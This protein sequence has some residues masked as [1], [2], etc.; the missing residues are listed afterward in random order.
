MRRNYISPQLFAEPQSPTPKWSLEL[1]N[2]FPCL[3]FHSKG[4]DSNGGERGRRTRWELP[5]IP[6]GRRIT[7]AQ[8]GRV[9]KQFCFSTQMYPRKIVIQV[10]TRGNTWPGWSASLSPHLM[11]A[12]QLHDRCPLSTRTLVVPSSS[13][14]PVL[15]ALNLVWIPLCFEMTRVLWV[16]L[17][18][19]SLV[20]NAFYLGKPSHKV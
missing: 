12:K 5:W 9:K 4:A 13:S 18:L 14:L 6:V 19:P 8:L 17:F 7:R 3:D 11:R 16:L 2:T 1:F 15:S 10:H 20:Q